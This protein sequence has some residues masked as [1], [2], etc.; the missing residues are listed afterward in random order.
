MDKLLDGTIGLTLGALVLII[1]MGIS[2]YFDDLY[3]DIT[4]LAQS[5]CDQEYNMDFESY[6]N[7]ELTCKPKEITKQKTYDGIVV[8]IKKKSR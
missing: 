6:I 3:G 2:F 5:I 7:G 8:N 4:E 1:V